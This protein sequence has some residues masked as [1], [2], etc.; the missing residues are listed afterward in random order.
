[1]K[2]TVVLI[3]AV[4]VLSALKAQ[5]DR[6]KIS[7]SIVNDQQLPLENASVELL[8]VKDSLL[9]KIAITDKA[10]LAVFENIHFGSYL[11]RVSLV[12]YATQY[13]PALELS[14]THSNIVVP[15]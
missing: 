6:G 11:V 8:K 14:G 5:T 7:I 4:C 3:L 9:I 1:M 15:V 12:N 10:G 13:S 2:K